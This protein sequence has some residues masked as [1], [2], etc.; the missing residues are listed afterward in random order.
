MPTGTTTLNQVVLFLAPV[1]SS[2]QAGLYL[3]PCVSS[4]LTLALRSINHHMAPGAANHYNILS[5]PTLYQPVQRLPPVSQ[6]NTMTHRQ[7]VPQRPLI[8]YSIC[9]PPG[10]SPPSPY[11]APLIPP[12][13]ANLYINLR[14]NFRPQPTP[15]D[16][17]PCG[18]PAQHLSAP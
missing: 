2:S 1:P 18:P 15:T 13:R 9:I 14:N 16:T 4:P 17:T 7:I 11:N 10:P 12:A 3:W 5:H 8:N 6:F